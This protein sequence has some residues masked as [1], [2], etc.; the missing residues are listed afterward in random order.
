[1][2]VTTDLKAGGLLQD[3]SNQ[4]S[5]AYQQV[6]GF[7]SQANQQV[8]DLSGAVVNKSTALWNCLTNT[9]K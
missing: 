2:K 5:Q 6:S 7:V 3:V 9:L 1:M 8:A 4:A